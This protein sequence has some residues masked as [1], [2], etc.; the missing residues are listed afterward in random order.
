MNERIRR[1]RPYPMVEL[2]RRKAAV[3]AR[4]IEVLDFGTGDPVEP[5][6][7]VIRDALAEAIPLI[8][9]YP[10][11][12]GEPELRQAF[13]SWFEERFGVPID[14]ATEVLPSRGSKEAMFHLPLVLVDPSEDKRGIVFPEPGYPVMEIGGL[15]AEADMHAIAMTADNDYRMDPAAIDPAVLARA[16]MVWLNYPHNPTGQDLPDEL[17]RAWVAAQQ[18]HGFV[19]CS[20]ECYTEI[21]FGEKPRSLLEFG[22]EGCLVFHSLSKRSGMT[23]YRSGMVAGDAAL[24]ADYRKARAAMGQA[25]TV[26]VQHASAAAW[27]DEKHVEQRRRIFGVKRDIMTKG[28][29][30]MGLEVYPTS[31]TFYLWVGVPAGTSDE[32]YAAALLEQGIVISPGSMFGQGNERFF[33]LALV[34]SPAGCK[35]ALERWSNV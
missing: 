13:A 34:P 15:Y 5:T 8:S 7:E 25:Q 31:S 23:A 27:G 24:I 26:W 32:A 3:A 22:R 12:A 30:A 1:L 4:G 18:E 2:A 28:L 17:W 33:R 35:Q 16:R 10:T 21:Y 19:L 14:P 20:D 9:Q 6:A 29:A 11:I